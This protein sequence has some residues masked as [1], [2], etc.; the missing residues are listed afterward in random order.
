MRGRKEIYNNLMPIMIIIA[1]FSPILTQL[2]TKHE[3]IMSKQHELCTYT[4]YLPTYI[5]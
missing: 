5:I 1:Y 3:E 4:I 2:T